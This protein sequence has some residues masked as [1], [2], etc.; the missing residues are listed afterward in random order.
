[1]SEK[2][3]DHGWLIPVVTAV[4][5]L[6]GGYLLSR[7]LENPDIQKALK[8]L[9]SP[10]NPEPPKIVYVPETPEEQE[11]RLSP[12]YTRGLGGLRPKW[13]HSATIYDP[14]SLETRDMRERVNAMLDRQRQTVAKRLDDEIKKQREESAKAGR[15][16]LRYT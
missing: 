2:K 11:Q 10:H 7:L 9:F 1:M 12:G 4:A 5:G 14:E 15:F 16:K 3:D 8:G 13:S 6:G